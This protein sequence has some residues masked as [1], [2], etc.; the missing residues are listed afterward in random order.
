MDEEAKEVIAEEQVP[1]V[2]TAFLHEIENLEPFTA[3]EIKKASK[4]RS[5]DNRP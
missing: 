4:G 1:E 2:L 3:E 5:K